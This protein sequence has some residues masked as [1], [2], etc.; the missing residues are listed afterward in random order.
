[1]GSVTV[2][3]ALPTHEKR[4]ALTRTS[5]PASPNRIPPAPQPRDAAPPRRGLWLDACWLLVWFLLAAAWCVGAAHEL[6]ATFDE[7][8]YVRGG[9]HHWRT[10][11]CHVL[12]AQGTMPLPVDVATLPLYLA[13]RWR[14]VPFDPVND[15]DALLPWARA[16]NL[17]FLALLLI[18]AW[19]AGR[20]VAGPWGGRL[21]VALLACEPTVLAHAALATTDIAVSACLLAFVYHYRTSRE[22]GTP[23]GRFRR[24]AL[25]TFWFAAAVLS[26]A[27]G[28]VFGP[29]CL[30]AVEVEQLARSGNLRDLRRSAVGLGLVLGS[31]LLLA[32]L[33]CGSRNDGP[34][35]AR[36]VRRAERLPAGPA[37]NVLLPL[38]RH[39]PLL[40][41]AANCIWFQ[42]RRNADCHDGCFLLGRRY[43]D[44]GVWYYFPVALAIKLTLPLLLLPL[45]LAV[46]DPR[47][48]TTWPCVAAGALVLFSV[49]CRVQIGVRFMLPLVALAVVGL[50]AGCVLVCRRYPRVRFVAS[51]AV[52]GSLGSAA[53]VWPNGLCYANELWG[54]TENCY[55]H[56]S[57][58]NHDWGQGIKELSRWQQAHGIARLDLWYFGTD[59]AL[60]RLPMRWLHPE[61]MPL[62]GPGGLLDLLKGRYL[63]VST[64]VL[65]G[66]PCSACQAAEYLRFC[67]PVDRTSTFLIYYV[68][69]EKDS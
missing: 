32:F 23:A 48:L 38:A 8:F 17:L 35:R 2:R 65:Y 63:A 10:G 30:L 49:T 31:G 22:A 53:V 58:S 41:N 27:S 64:T 1:M 20:S 9:L 21:A 66:H 47:A 34:A 7:P 3:K 6:G 68:P 16:G 57:D 26:K 18:Y 24:W 44:C 56:L 69:E 52:L 61:A 36:L 13:E 15:L 55:L 46:L 50:A 43:A 14:G 37:R 5:Y 45:A 29:L 4:S 19:K 12:T 28:V 40:D 51:A 67:Q 62:H 60:Q 54:G 39:V 11:Q 42:V 59:P 33:Y 25:P